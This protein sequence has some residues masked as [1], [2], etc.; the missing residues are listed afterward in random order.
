MK[1][2]K[3]FYS[4]A[5]LNFSEK[6]V[7]KENVQNQMRARNKKERNN[8]HR[9]SKSFAVEKNMYIHSR[10]MHEYNKLPI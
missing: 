5:D 3:K 1:N 4:K 6:T 9:N 8:I 7:T 10:K 2:C